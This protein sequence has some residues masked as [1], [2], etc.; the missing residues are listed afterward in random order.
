VVG[1]SS[2]VRWL[3][4][5][6]IAY[7]RV[8]DNAEASDPV[9]GVTLMHVVD[10]SGKALTAS[11]PERPPAGGTATVCACILDGCTR[12]RLRLKAWRESAQAVAD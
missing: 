5:S 9:D 8:E 4:E 10:A 3:L 2:N 6:P 1:S 11:E 12:S 7:P